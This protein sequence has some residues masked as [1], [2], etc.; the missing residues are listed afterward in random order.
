MKPAT[1]LA[2]IIDLYS[3]AG[4]ASLGIEEGTGQP[5]DVAINHDANAIAN[6]WNNHRATIHLQTDVDAVDPRSVVGPGRTVGLLWG[7][8]KCTHFSPAR[9]GAP[10]S[11]QAR[12]DG[13]SVIRWVREVSP[14]VVLL[15]NVPAWLTWGPLHP[16]DHPVVKLRGQPIRERAGETWNAWVGALRELGYVVEWKRLRGRDYGAPTIRERLFVVARRDGRPIVWPEPTHGPGRLPYRTAAECMDWRFPMLSVFATRAEAKRW[17]RAVKADGTPK[18]PLADATLA[19]IAEGI[20]RFVLGKRRP[21]LVNLTHGGRVED[22]DEPMRTITAAHRGEKALLAPMISPVKSWGGGGNEAGPVDEPLRTITASKR[23]EF[24]IAAGVLA[25]SVMCHYGASVGARIDEPLPT[26]VA[27]GGGKQVLVS[28]VLVETGNGEREG[29]APR[30]RDLEQPFWTVTAKG[31]QGALAAAWLVKNFGGP[32]G[33]ATPGAPLDQPAPTIS[34]RD[35]NSVGAVFLEKL[36]S[37]AQAGSPVDEPAPTVTGGGG[38]LA[39]VGAALAR[40]GAMERARAVAELLQRF[41]AKHRK[42]QPAPAP[43]QLNAD[44]LVTLDIDGE[45]WVLAD[46]VMRMVEPEELKLCQGFGKDYVLT[47][48]KEERV[49][50][51]GN[52]VNPQVAAALAR[53]NYTPMPEPKRRSR[54]P[55]PGLFGDLAAK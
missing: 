51:I 14:H 21:Y 17:A 29:Q 27:G 31:S 13:W 38:H 20:H 52:S 1:L 32:N 54:K 3:G 4:G 30:V 35:H 33:H 53:A 25:P 44:G 40:A 50:R 55:A 22:L 28:G 49:A 26:I 11:P 34:T 46:I 19:R 41:P 8:P 12:E 7:S 47:G 48:T 15:E 23:G 16:D 45:A 9:G 43:L 24:A 18:R 39:V 37:S 5:V 36:Y 10:K 2:L 42:G 6:H